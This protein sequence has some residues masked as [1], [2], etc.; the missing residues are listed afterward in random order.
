MIVFS[1]FLVF[2][3]IFCKHL[4]SE[5]YIIYQLH[6]QF[7]CTYRRIFSSI[8]FCFMNLNLQPNILFMEI[9]EEVKTKAQNLLK[10]GKVKKEVE[11]D[12][13][14][15]F[16]VQGETETHSVIFDKESREFF[17]DCPYFTLKEG[18]C[19]H[20]EAVRILLEGSIDKT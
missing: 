5:P 18:Y 10:E 8:N 15:H 17:C 20:I 12:K 16:K 9:S 14:I 2:P 13:R 4:E 7:S 19:S 11:T 3:C 1:S 6:S